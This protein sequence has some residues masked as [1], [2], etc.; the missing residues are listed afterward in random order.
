MKIYKKLI[1]SSF[2]GL[3]C[4]MT[5]WAQSETL[6][7]LAKEVSNIQAE[8][9]SL[10][11]SSLEEA[12]LIDNAIKVIGQAAN[13]VTESISKGDTAAALATINFLNE[14]IGDIVSQTPKDFITEKTESDLSAFSKEDMKEIQIITKSMKK[15]KKEKMKTLVQ[16]MVVINKKGVDTFAMSK[17]LNN[18]GVETITAK[19][20]KAVVKT[21]SK[22][23]IQSLTEIKTM[24]QATTEIKPEEKFS[25]FVGETE[26]E[27]S[28]SLRQVEVLK[29]G[30]N[31]KQRAYDI[32]K[33]GKM[34]G[35]SDDEIKQGVYAVKAGDWEGQKEVV[36]KIYEAGGIEV[37][38]AELNAEM[39]QEMIDDAALN[40]IMNGKGKSPEELAQQVKG[41]LS[42]NESL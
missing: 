25:A 24:T 28:M 6:E 2:V 40:A 7:D 36:A 5:S 20:V 17:E 41:I 34:V 33:Y 29:S 22:K 4:L 9:K 19:E 32:E 21:V 39:E 18:I 26:E 1:L 3:F 23:Q 42:N 13:L 27:V 14:S 12:I 8:L 37:T 15:R 31:V 38:E 30:D 10:P 35:L 11:T 16:D